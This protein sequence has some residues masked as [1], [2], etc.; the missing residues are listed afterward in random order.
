MVV[1]LASGIDCKSLSPV[2]RQ[3]K[4][5]GYDCVHEPCVWLGEKDVFTCEDGLCGSVWLSERALLAKWTRMSVCG[6]N[7]YGDDI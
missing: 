1:T 4:P 7:T 5:F 2:Q 3:G 6:L